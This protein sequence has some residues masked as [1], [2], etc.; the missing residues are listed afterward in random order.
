MGRASLERQDHVVRLE[1]VRSEVL[2]DL[3]VGLELRGGGWAGGQA[4]PDATEMN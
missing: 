1:P 2:R 3:H 4:H